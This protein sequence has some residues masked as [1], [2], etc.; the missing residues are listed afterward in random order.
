MFFWQNFIDN[1]VKYGEPGV[2]SLPIHLPIS[3]RWNHVCSALRLL[4]A[5][6]NN[7]NNNNVFLDAEHK[8]I[9]ASC[10]IVRMVV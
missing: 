1:N 8:D 2:S 9:S 5:G 4:P 10:S 3:V 7:N 6:S